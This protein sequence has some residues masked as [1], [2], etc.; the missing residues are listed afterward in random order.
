MQQ[1]NV[2]RNL[3]EEP[4]RT[5]LP[6]EEDDAG[7]LFNIQREELFVRGRVFPVAREVLS[8]LRGEKVEASFPVGY[9][10]PYVIIEHI[11]ITMIMKCFQT[12]QR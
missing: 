6:H 7:M 12:F 5:S 2:I 11:S 8:S 1:I 9:I 10:Q 3:V 4:G